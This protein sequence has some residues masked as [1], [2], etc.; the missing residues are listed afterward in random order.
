MSKLLSIPLTL[1]GEMEVQR[2]LYLCRGEFSGFSPSDSAW[3]FIL[4]MGT[5]FLKEVVITSPLTGSVRLSVSFF[6]A[7]SFSVTFPLSKS[8]AVLFAKD[9]DL[10]ALSSG[11][12]DSG[13]VVV[14]AV[15]SSYF[16]SAAWFVKLVASCFD[17]ETCE[18][19]CEPASLS[20]RIVS[21]CCATALS[22]VKGEV[23]QLL[24]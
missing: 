23:L 18:E 19:L 9:S 24:P 17:R 11:S 12:T 21:S 20:S 8:S 5:T 14:I 16:S 10:S 4:L 15:S 22:Q 3:P 13:S 6:P 7:S 1:S 2:G